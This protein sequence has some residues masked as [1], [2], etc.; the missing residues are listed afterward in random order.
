MWK[1]LYNRAGHR[2]QY[3]AC[4]IT[5]AKNTHAEYVILTAFPLK[6]RLHE[7]SSMLP[8]TYIA[9]LVNRC[10][11]Q[12]N[13]KLTHTLL[14]ATTNI[15]RQQCDDLCT[16][17]NKFLFHES[18]PRQ[19]RI[20]SII[21]RC[22]APCSLVGMYKHFGRKSVSIFRTEVLFL[23]NINFDLPGSSTMSLLS[24]MK[25]HHRLS[26]YS[27]AS[28]RQDC[29]L[30]LVSPC[31]VCSGGIGG[32]NGFSSTISVFPCLYHY[33]TGVQAI[34]KSRSH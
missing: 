18:L 22:T 31:G 26:S 20:L 17:R 4:W 24:T 16:P 29:V 7:S 9:C 14:S 1:I 28:D 12:I 21:V 19:S 33:T 25:T 2:W 5:K 34:H 8:Y 10:L 30:S 3:G 11:S 15:N 27:S 6:P 23:R 32:G 13:K